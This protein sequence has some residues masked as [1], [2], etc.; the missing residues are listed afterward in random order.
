MAQL[1]AQTQ[2]TLEKKSGKKRFKRDELKNIKTFFYIY[3]YGDLD[4]SVN[5]FNEPLPAS[6]L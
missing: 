3:G 4:S 6:N 2:K 1:R 5:H